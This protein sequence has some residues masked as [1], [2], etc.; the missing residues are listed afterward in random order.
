M[1]WAYIAGFFDGEGSVSSLRAEAQDV[2][3]F[4]RMYPPMDNGWYIRRVTQY[5]D[6]RKRK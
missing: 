6:E 4:H 2:I 3:R 5:D 1:N